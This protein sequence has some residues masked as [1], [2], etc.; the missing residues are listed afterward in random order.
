MLKAGTRVFISAGAS[1]IGR[2]MAET[3]ARNEARVCICDVSEA[4]LQEARSHLP[5]MILKRA[6]VADPEQIDGLFNGIQER[7][8]G[9]DVLINN[10]GIAGP[11]APIEEITPEQWSRTIEV[12]LN[13]QFHCARRAV[14]LLKAAGGGSI[15]NISSVAGR[16]GLP[17]R[18]PYSASKWAIIGLTKSLAM[19]LGPANIRV[20]ALLPGTVQGDRIRQVMEA[21][22]KAIGQSFEEVEREVL[23]R[24]SLRTYTQPSDIAN[25]ALFL[26]SEE[27]YRVSGQALS[28]CGNSEALQ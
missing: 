18:T 16:L 10:A 8:G 6:D 15:I 23:N 5:D 13:G 19:E 7:L 2:V 9:L 25:M 21:K 22:A 24:I 17:L 12:N 27:G 1:G 4:R 26:C 28:V 20:N 14:P 11:T 3:F